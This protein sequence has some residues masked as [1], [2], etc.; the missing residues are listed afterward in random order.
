VQVSIARPSLASLNLEPRFDGAPLGN[1]TGFVVERDT[2]AYLFTNWHVVAGRRADTGEPLSPTGGIPNQLRILHNVASMMGSWVD[3]VELLY[4]DGSPRWLEH[5][6]Y[7]GRVDVVALELT[8]RTGI[9]LYGFDP[10]TTPHATALNVATSLSIVGFPFGLTSGGALG[11][12]AR[13]TVAT[14]PALDYEGMPCFL[15]DSRTRPGQSGSPVLFYAAGGVVA[16]ADG[17]TVAFAG[18]VEHFHGIYSGR[19]NAQSDLGFVW[20]ASVVRDLIDGGVPGQATL[21]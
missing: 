2:R 20:K 19:V 8:D 16:M 15:I 11:V 21:S 17:S 3:K 13:G 10:W 14:E 18:P 1:A 9:D 7:G 12:W 5:P 4:H 6:A